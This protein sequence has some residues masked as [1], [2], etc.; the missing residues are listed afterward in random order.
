MPVQIRRG[1]LLDRIRRGEPLVSERAIREAKGKLVE[2]LKR[3]RSNW[4][5]DSGESRNAF[6]VTERGIGN[7]TD[8]AQYVHGG[9][10]IEQAEEYIQRNGGQYLADAVERELR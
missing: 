8:Y 1:E 5:V 2:D 3:G 6:Y 7:R 9:R 4:P 10:A